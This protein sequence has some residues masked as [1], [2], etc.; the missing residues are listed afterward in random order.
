M[1]WYMPDVEDAFPY[2]TDFIPYPE[3]PLVK[4]PAGGVWHIESLTNAGYPFCDLMIGIPKLRIDVV[5]QNPYVSVYDVECDEDDF[6][7]NGLAILCPT[8]CTVHEVLNGEYSVTMTHPM[9]EDGKWKLIIE[10]NYLKVLGQIFTIMV[11]EQD[12][13]AHEVRCTAEHVFYQLNDG[14]IF[15][16]R[17]SDEPAPIISGSTGDEVLRNIIMMSTF[18]AGSDVHR[19]LYQFYSDMTGIAFQ[20]EVTE[21]MTPIAAILGGGGFCEVCGGKLLRDNFYFSVCNEMEDSDAHAFDL[22]V[23]NNLHGIKRTVD[24]T[25]MCSYIRVY[26]GENMWTASSWAPGSFPIRQIP[27]NIVRSVTIHQ[28]TP[29][30][31]ALIQ[32]K[33]SYFWRYCQPVIAYKFDIADSIGN[34]VYDDI[35]KMYRYKVGD[36][37]IVY[38]DR[39]D[40]AVYLEI[41]E[42]VKDGITGRTLSFSVGNKR[43]FTRPANIP[44]EVHVAEIQPESSAFIWR[45]KNGVILRDKNNYTLY[46]EVTANG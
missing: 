27:H 18:Y 46:T 17:W 4:P 7:T 5:N 24:V 31:E 44:A 34:P 28:Q 20:E 26:N 42:T 25:S 22:R 16:A 1:A 41:T 37:G 8:E 6:N 14:W 19:F 40:G 21:G 15:P 36:K 10:R 9:D 35:S 33:E 12:F 11:V 45:D 3:K 13:N 2:N 43:N 38:D 39:L 23:G 30:M 32:A 29:N